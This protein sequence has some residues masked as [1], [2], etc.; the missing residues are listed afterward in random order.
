MRQEESAEAEALAEPPDVDVD[1][2]VEVDEE[3]V[4][5]TELPPEVVGHV[6]TVRGVHSGTP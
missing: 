6:A 2:D 3:L 1:V 5:E 4:V